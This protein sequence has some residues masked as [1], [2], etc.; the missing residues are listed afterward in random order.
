MPKR[1][2]LQLSPR[3]PAGLVR[4]SE[5]DEEGEKKKKKETLLIW[6]SVSDIFLLCV[7]ALTLSLARRISSVIFS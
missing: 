1:S 6:N 2:R 5:S 3:F 7:V 4:E